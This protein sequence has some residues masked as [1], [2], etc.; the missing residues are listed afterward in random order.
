MSTLKRLKRHDYTVAWLCTWALSEQVAAIDMLDEL[1]ED[2]LLPS[3][4][5]KAHTSGSFEGHNI[6]VACLP[7]G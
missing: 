6:I 3:G 2:L 4:D 7:F 1:H 5:D